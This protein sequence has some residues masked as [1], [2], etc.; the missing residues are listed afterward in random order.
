VKLRSASGVDEGK[1]QKTTEKPPR[2]PRTTT[3]LPAH[4]PRV[5]KVILV[6]TDERACAKCG[7]E[8]T[9]IGHDLSE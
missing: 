5:E 1:K 8:R 3:P 6:P 2:Q 4:L 9:C 7:R